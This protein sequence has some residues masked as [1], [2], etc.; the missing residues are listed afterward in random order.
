[1]GSLLATMAGISN[2]RGTVFRLL[3]ANVIA[4]KKLI[5]AQLKISE[6]F[7]RCC[8]FQ[9]LINGQTSLIYEAVT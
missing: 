6:P 7:F 3:I 8:V 9:I 4:P 1:M 2:P 5:P